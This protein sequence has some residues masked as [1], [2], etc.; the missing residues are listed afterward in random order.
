MKMNQVIVTL[1][2]PVVWSDK[3]VPNNFRTTILFWLILKDR[4]KGVHTLVEIFGEVPIT[5]SSIRISIGFMFEPDLE[6]YVN[7]IVYDPVAK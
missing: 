2:T 7:E 1:S 4:L 6:Q 3:D 5:T